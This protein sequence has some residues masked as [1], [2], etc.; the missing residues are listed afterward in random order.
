M[1]YISLI[2]LSFFLV[3]GSAEATDLS[4]F[5]P[6]KN[7]LFKLDSNSGSVAYPTGY[8]YYTENGVSAH[9]HVYTDCVIVT[10]A[11]GE[12]K[13]MQAIYDLE[14]NMLA[15]K[16]TPDRKELINGVSYDFYDYNVLAILQSGKNQFAYIY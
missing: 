10:V 6:E 5:I 9:V 15:S 12:D 1:R 8:Q 11:T 13:G 3:A 16:V 2:V 7:Q 4:R 14:I